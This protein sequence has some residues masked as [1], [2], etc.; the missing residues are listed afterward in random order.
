VARGAR[1]SPCVDYEVPLTSVGLHRRYQ[2]SRL[3][4]VRPAP[5][6][7]RDYARSRQPLREAY[8]CPAVKSPGR[9]RRWRRRRRRRAYNCG[10]EAMRSCVG[11]GGSRHE[12][13]LGGQ[14]Q[15]NDHRSL[16]KRG[17]APLRW[18]CTPSR[19]L[20][21]CQ[22]PGANDGRVVQMRTASSSSADCFRLAGMSSQKS[23]SSTCR[24]RRDAGSLLRR[25]SSS[26]RSCAG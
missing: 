12:Q 8:R 4:C 14:Q 5:S 6:A 7:G 2:P 21:A 3:K 13:D 10:A 26:Y 23:P 19:Q 24:C 22:V 15:R 9:W 20:C 17:Q 11:A 1:S 25:Q 16:R 18:V